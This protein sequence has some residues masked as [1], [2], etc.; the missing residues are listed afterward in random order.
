MLITP[1]A[2][3]PS[4]SIYPEKDSLKLK[5]SGKPHLVMEFEMPSKLYGR[6]M[7]ARGKDLDLENTI[8][9]FKGD[10]VSLNEAHLHGQTTLYYER[11]SYSV[12]ARKK[13][14]LCKGC[15]G[16]G[17][18]YLVSLSMDR[19]YYHNRLSFDLLNVLGL[20][21]LQYA[22]SELKIN[23]ESQG[24]YLILQRPQ[25]WALKDQGSPYIVRRGGEHLVDRERFQ[26]DLDKESKKKY[27][28]QFINIYKT[29]NQSS[30]EEL[31]AKLNE[32][33]HLEDYMRWLAFNYI[34]KCG[35]YSD[36]L[37]FYVDPQSKKLKIIP[38]DYDDIFMLQPHEGIKERN[39]KLDPSSLIFSSEDKLDVKIATDSY[40]YDQYLR[41]FS[42][43][44]KELSDDKIQRIL[45]TIYSDLSPMYESKPILDAASKDGYRTSPAILRGELNSVYDF[46]EGQRVGLLNKKVPSK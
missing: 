44:L 30:G 45:T 15:D 32:L 46:F 8:I 1:A 13:I 11:K 34:I 28:D 6:I 23:G 18:F 24:I 31:H 17:A 40:L 12:D 26:K 3:R 21:N 14:K 2:A 33:M 25:D 10:T 9:K 38:W 42:A 16:L 19:N 43:V 4:V 20:F 5:S 41:H 29:I 39:L 7:A 36:E 35:D 27:H 37:Y 22:Y